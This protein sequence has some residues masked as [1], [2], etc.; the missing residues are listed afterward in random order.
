[1]I[2]P[3][4]DPTINDEINALRAR[5]ETPIRKR[6]EKTFTTLIDTL[7]ERARREENEAEQDRLISHGLA[8]QQQWMPLAVRDD[9]LLAWRAALDHPSVK[10]YRRYN[11]FAARE[12]HNVSRERWT[13]LWDQSSLIMSLHRR[14][15]EWGIV[16]NEEVTPILNRAKQDDPVTGQFGPLAEDEYR[17]VDLIYQR[18]EENIYKFHAALIR[19]LRMEAEWMNE[20]GYAEPGAEMDFPKN[21]SH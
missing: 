3:D 15:E 8:M 9:F 12:I 19:G 6:S 5:L 4:S 16:K 13:L 17:Q 2:T 21:A 18:L 1:V 20:Y 7:M 10:F 14:I 11:L